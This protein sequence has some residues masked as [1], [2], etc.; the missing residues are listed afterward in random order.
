[1]S[2]TIRNNVERILNFLGIAGIEIFDDSRPDRVFAWD[3]NREMAVACTINDT[4]WER[5]VYDPLHGPSTRASFRERT[6][7]S[8]QV[9][10]HEISQVNQPE[11]VDLY[12]IEIDFDQAPPT[13]PETILIHAKEVLVNAIT[14]HLTD[15][16]DIARRLDKRL[17]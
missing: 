5:D 10:F 6:R 15:Q 16:A 13:N 14:G 9:C 4:H 7:P 1:M 2:P 17:A 3:R 11:G 12:F 8:M